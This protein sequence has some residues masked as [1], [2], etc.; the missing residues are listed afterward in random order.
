MDPE[1]ASYAARI[2]AASIAAAFIIEFLLVIVYLRGAVAA[3][4][5]PAS[6]LF[7]PLVAIAYMVYRWLLAFAVNARRAAQTLLPPGI[8]GAFIAFLMTL[9]EVTRQPAMFLIAT[10]YLAE[11]GVGLKLYR[12]IEPISRAGALLFI[13]GMT[14]FIT[15]LPLAIFNNQAAAAPL[16]F[17]AV[18][19]LGLALLLKNSLSLNQPLKRAEAR[20]AAR[21]IL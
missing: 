15:T 17:N 13:G 19:T 2:F 21:E 7:I 12:D 3:F 11:L 18:K 16:L 9:F 20:A 1:R 5:P 6:L 8:A 4:T 14:L 10:V